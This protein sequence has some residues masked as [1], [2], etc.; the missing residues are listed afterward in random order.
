MT[1]ALTALACALLVQIATV[2]IMASVANRELGHKVTTGPRDGALPPMSP[3]LGRLRR[4][5]T[6]GFEGLALFA[7]AVLILTLAQISTPLTT[8]AAWTY[9]AARLAYLPAYAYGWTPWRSVIWFVGLCATLVLLLSA[10]F[11]LS[12]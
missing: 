12:P 3:R 11:P 1:P 7:P 5:C 6:N 10:L 9:V 2:G 4:A 8:L